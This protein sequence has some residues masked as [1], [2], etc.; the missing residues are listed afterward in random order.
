M[1]FSTRLLYTLAL[2]SSSS[3]ILNAKPLILQLDLGVRNVQFAGINWAEGHGWFADAGLDLEVRR[4][5][6]GV[7]E[8]VASN[9]GTVGSI[10]SG[11]F[12]AAVAEGQPLVAIGTMF[13]AS[14]LGLISLAESNIKTPSDLRGRVVAIH[15]DGREALAT[16]LAYAKVDPSEVTVIKAEYGNEPLLRGEMDAKQG[17]VVDEFVKLQTEGYEVTMIPYREYGHVAYSQ[18]MFVSRE[19]LES[20]RSDLIKFLSVA[21]RGWVAVAEDIPAAAQYTIDHFQPELSFDYQNQSLEMI[22]ELVWAESEQT[23]AMSKDT[24]AINAASYLKTHEGMHLPPM[25]KWVDFSLATEADSG[26]E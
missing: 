11:L 21:N 4:W 19:T 26:R 12:L 10:E 22:C 7:A 16:A 6:A 14:P 23:S 8:T 17:Y 15:G 24:W 18:V 20:R 1:R 9:P 25:E 2:F 5:S 13:Q 3:L